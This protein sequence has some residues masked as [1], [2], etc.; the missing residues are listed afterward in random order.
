[1]PVSFGFRLTRVRVSVRPGREAMPGSAVGLTRR[2]WLLG[3]VLRL[4]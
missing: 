1:M 2:Y 3:P 4:P